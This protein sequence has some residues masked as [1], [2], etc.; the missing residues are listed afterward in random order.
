[1]CGKDG[2]NQTLAEKQFSNL[3]LNVIKRVGYK[4]QIFMDFY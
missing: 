3:F 2:F 1:M 4:M